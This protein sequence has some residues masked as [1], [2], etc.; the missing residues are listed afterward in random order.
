MM[1][2]PLSLAYLRSRCHCLWKQYCRKQWNWMSV[3]SCP[4]QCSIAAGLMRADIVGPLRPWPVAEMR[5]QRHEQRILREPCGLL[6]HIFVKIR[7]CAPQKARKWRAA[8]WADGSH[9]AGHSRRAQGSRPS[10]ARPAPPASATGGDELI[11]VDEVG[12]ARKGRKRLIGR[13]AV[14]RR[15]D[16]QD[17]Q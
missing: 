11:R 3:S 12:I 8:A 7:R 5:L 1:R 2:M 16:R 9:R 17:L 10:S 6:L 14:A 13:I 4:R 15:A